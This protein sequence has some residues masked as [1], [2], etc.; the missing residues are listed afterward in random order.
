MAL[1]CGVSGAITAAIGVQQV[2]ILTTSVLTLPVLAATNGVP[3][4]IG[5]L[6]ASVVG[7]VATYFY[8]FN[9]SMVV[10]E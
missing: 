9:D 7:F 5:I 2:G 1:A 4:V 3:H 8:G 10:D 6:V